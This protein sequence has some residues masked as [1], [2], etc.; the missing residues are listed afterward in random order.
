MNIL[1][2]LRKALTVWNG[3][4]SFLIALLFAGMLLSLD[5]PGRLVFH[6]VMT[7]T[8]LYPVQAT[9]S[10][11]DGTLNVF[12]ENERLRRENAALR[13][14]NDWLHEA[15]R[16]L[17]RLGAMA[18]FQESVSLRLKPA[19]VIAQDP[20][21]FQSAWVIDL[22]TADSVATNMP[23]LTSRGVVGKIVKV[24]RNHSLVQLLSDHAFKVSVHSSRSRARGIL[25]S[26]GPERL[27]ARFPAG[28][29]VA[30]GDSL[31]T[32]GLGGVFPKGLRL[33]TAGREITR[34]ERE[35]QDVIRT[36][37][38]M[39]FQELNTVEE[40]FVLVKTDSW[41]LADPTIDSLVAIDTAAE[42]R[43]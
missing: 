39:P 26:D 18:R 8:V 37:R 1:G 21:R 19:R 4:F 17:P 34:Q 10:S 13:A 38:V 33:G 36:F 9:L 2:W 5:G 20:G 7:G 35:H 28:S 31:V 15:H 6:R 29:D 25:E 11:F 3:V 16:Q 22:G 43:P 30:Q 23:V 42:A 41:V 40:V 27:V 24:Y 12:G 32:T 14:E